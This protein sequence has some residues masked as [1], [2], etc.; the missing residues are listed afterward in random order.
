MTLD[1]QKEQFSFAYVRAVSAAAGIAVSEPTIDDDSIDLLF[2]QRG[3]GGTFRSPRIDAQVKCS[4]VLDLADDHIAFPLKLKNYDELRHDD[5][6][7]PRILIV[8]RVPDNLPE[9]IAHS[10]DN[11]ALR[12]CGYWM[13]LKGKPQSVNETSVTVHVPRANL[14]TVDGLISLMQRVG[15]GQPL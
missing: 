6:L 9:W 11:L 8:V 14:F 12:R 2:Q 15:E 10:E 7:V 5:V 4:A 3:G 13:S 1:D